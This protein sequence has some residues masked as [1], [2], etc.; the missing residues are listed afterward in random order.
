MSFDGSQIQN[1]IYISGESPWPVSF[2]DW[3]ARAQ[4]ILEPGPFGY[5]AGGAGSEATMRANLEAFERRRLRPKMLTGP[6]RPRVL[7]LGSATVTVALS[8]PGRYRLALRYSPYW[9]SPGLCI[10]ERTDGMVELV[11]A[12]SGVFRLRFS[13]TAAR[14][15]AALAGQPSPCA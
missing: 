6:G 10:G 11:A 12:Q 5:I 1:A 3:E 2:A 13:V 4:E 8:R 7:A 15:V 14:A 9:T